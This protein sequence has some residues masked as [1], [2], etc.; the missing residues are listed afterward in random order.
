VVATFTST[1]PNYT[2]GSGTGSITIKKATPTVSVSGGPFPYDGNQ[3]SATATA[4]GVGGA[5]VSGS[6]S[7]TY[8]G[9]ATAPTNAKTS[10]AVVAT[11][12]STD[13][14]YT[15]GTGNGTLTIKQATPTVTVA[16]DPMPTY[17]GNPHS[18]TAAAVGVDGHTVVSGSFSFT[19]D[20]STTAPTNAKTSYA[21][22]ATFTSTDP[23][24]TTGSGTGSITIKKTNAN[25]VVTPYS[26][27]YDG[28]PHTAAGTAKGVQN[29][30]LT[31][32]NLTG[33]THTNAAIYGTDPWTFTD[34]TGNYNYTTGTVIDNIAKANPTILVTPYS[35]TYDANP[36]SA[37]GTATGVKGE[38]LVGLNLA[39]TVHTN[40]VDYPTDPWTFTDVTGNY[41]PASGTVH[42]NITDVAP[43]VKILTPASGYIVPLGT[44]TFTGSFS[45]IGPK[46]PY[47]AKFTFDGGTTV[48]GNLT[49]NADGP[50]GTVTAS[51]TFTTAG[52]YNIT[53][54]VKD[55]YTATGTANT[56]NN[57]STSPAF[58]VVY[59][60]SAGFVTGGGWIMSPAGAYVANPALT[61]KANFGFVSK[62]QKGATVPTGE[63]EFNFQVANF[64]FHASVYQWMVVSGSQAQYKGT[65][66][67][68]GAGNY[69]FMLTASDSPDGFRIKITN[70][71]DGSVI[72]DNMKAPLDDSIGNTQPIAGG[73]IV[74]HK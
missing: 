17:D 2:T 30:L 32:L 16:A 46:G 33:T 8:D 23:N 44:V 14:N 53:L 62:Y 13:P 43:T 66:A 51:Y 27:P 7:F 10:Y 28:N 21:V 72:Y 35:V 56:V 22:V 69:N 64:N 73:S 19:Y 3:H 12:T 26:I 36:H 63:T 70:P 74:I 37:T 39:G 24:Y 57:D 31:G 47:T 58:I 54:S 4:T 38:S 59:D 6:F 25:I 15:G 55:G 42:D 41:N 9:S 67:I 40:P 1:D 61:G 29:E 11:F 49:P 20:G 5:P 68:N 18:T 48:I 71:A 60:P 50:S 65:G 34:V 52:V 45:D